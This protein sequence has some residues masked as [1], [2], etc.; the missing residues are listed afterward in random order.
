LINVIERAGNSKECMPN[1]SPFICHHFVNND[2]GIFLCPLNWSCSAE[3]QF[4]QLSAYN[5]LRQ[6]YLQT[7]SCVLLQKPSCV[8]FSGGS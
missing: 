7:L 3:G 1:P 8:L 2:S 6:S 5:Q 4:F